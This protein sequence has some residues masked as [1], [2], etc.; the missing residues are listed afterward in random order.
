MQK[1]V[2]QGP[3]QLFVMDEGFAFVAVGLVGRI[4]LLGSLNRCG[5][6]S[7]HIAKPRLTALASAIGFK[8]V[9]ANAIR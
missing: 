5:E 2:F 9:G 4:D 1:R 8:E 3:I 6:A 7:C